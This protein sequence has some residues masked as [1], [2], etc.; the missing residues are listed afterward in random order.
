[1]PDIAFLP[2]LAEKGENAQEEKRPNTNYDPA[3]S[4]PNP[5]A[6]VV[7]TSQGTHTE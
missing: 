6:A 3:N 2:D 5:T 4:A 1:V 7:A